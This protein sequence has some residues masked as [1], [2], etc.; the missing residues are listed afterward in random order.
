MTEGVYD[1]LRKELLEGRLAAGAWLREQELAER[2]AVSRTPVREALRL[3]AQEGLVVIEAN[4]GVRVPELTVDDAVATYAVRAR[5]EAMA[6]GLAASRA[7][8][9]GVARLRSA[10]AEIEA[11]EDDDLARHIVADDAFHALIAELGG[12][13]VLADMIDHIASR[14][15]RVKI[16]T[17]DVNV[18]RLARGQHMAIVAAIEAGRTVDAERAM[19]AHVLA[20]LAIVRERL[21]ADAHPSTPTERPTA[22]P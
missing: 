17:R 21:E 2:L 8:A 13:A 16:L 4:R 19:E 3:L 1:Y 20:N 12:N 10:L 15:R 5:L 22:H 14:V 7:G 11:L 18:T 9:E 6:A